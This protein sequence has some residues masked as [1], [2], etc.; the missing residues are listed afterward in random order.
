M[1]DPPAP[2]MSTLLDRV[3]RALAPRYDVRRE[4][5][6]GGMGV[7][8]LALDPRLH[9]DVAIKVLQPELA[10]A[11]G[12]E[13][14]LAEARF[15]A[16]LRH[17]SI[18]PVHD[19]GE[20]EGLL[21][22][23][24][25]LVEGPTLAARLLE[26]PLGPAAVVRLAEDLLGAL[27]VA[28]RAG[29]IHRDLKP[30]N[31]FL[32]G[33]RAILGDFGI[34][35]SLA[36]SISPLSVPGLL[37]GTLDY[38]APEQLGGGPATVRTDLYAVGLVL[39]A[40]ATGRR[41]PGLQQPERADWSGMSARMAAALKRALAYAPEDR[42]PDAAS[43]ARAIR[44][45]A[46]HRAGRVAAALVT[47][48]AL[49]YALYRLIP[50]AT[51]APP[52]AG[53]SIESAT[54]S[55][56]PDAMG[57]SLIAA[58]AAELAGHPDLVVR[59]F[60]SGRG[61][62]GNYRVIPAVS[63]AGGGV[64]VRLRLIAAEGML[65][66]DTT[67]EADPSTWRTAVVGLTASLVSH[68][69]L[70]QAAM[71]PWLPRQALPTGG[72]RGIA[73]WLRAEN[74]YAEERWEEAFDGFTEAVRL[75]G[76]CALC[77]FRLVDVDRWLGRDADTALRAALR[78]EIGRFPAHYQ[79]LIRSWA[80]PYPERFD[81][82]ERLADANPG[83]FLA[84]FHLGDELFHRGPLYGRPRSDALA[85]FQRTVALR[86]E[87]TPAWEH[88]A[89]LSI[90]EGDSAGS[91]R[92]LRVLRRA[93]ATPGGISFALRRFLEL[94]ARWRFGDPAA[95]ALTDQVLADSGLVRH[96]ITAAGGRFMLTA[97][98]P[99]G[100]V[101]LGRRLAAWEDR[102]EAHRSGLLAMLHGF[103]VLGRLDSVLAVGERLRSSDRDP[104]TGL[105][106]AELAAALVLFDPDSVWDADLSVTGPL[107]RLAAPGAA[108]PALRQRAAWMLSLLARR[109]GSEEEAVRWDRVVRQ[110]HGSSRLP[111]L[112]DAWAAAER[113]EV[114]RVAVLTHASL[115]APGAKWDDPFEDA[116]ARLARS[117]AYEQTEEHAQAV[118]E[119]RWH[120]HLHVFNYLQG[121]P[122]PGE[123]AWALGS[124]ARW[125]RYG[126]LERAGQS[127]AEMC[128]VLGAIARHWVH[129]GPRER[130]R[131]TLA[132]ERMARSGCAESPR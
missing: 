125:R 17:P 123:V 100:A 90:A 16:R 36:Q 95:A 64:R 48:A 86:P 57:D 49:A 80:V 56:L 119:L 22:Y 82:L 122:Q 127:G 98:A 27:A 9:R 66:V 128:A 29:V 5:A 124:V 77:R 10:T 92:A 62:P 6:R 75:D 65:M 110:V 23:V 71:D 34:A 53:V 73:A 1:P 115:L 118:D 31:V 7:V 15:L 78:A 108:D 24:M 105:Y 76:T 117:R 104:A 21:Y 42:W 111:A 4:L 85:P 101:A 116:V 132:R 18:I 129:G 41:W 58:L 35:R 113:G 38:M 12:A 68:V 102:P 97:E 106:A 131:A 74:L 37:V 25:D 72:P 14:F 88:L 130:A 40:A 43:F 112:L 51:P 99:Q 45:P 84:T 39:Y 52:Q 28:H 67:A 61:G 121:D 50:P 69:W 114:A 83:F 91:N 93:V 87:F 3:R 46:G 126:L 81:S 32:E 96:P 13:R 107:E 120:E 20:A 89:W 54:V 60:R 59:R 26:G 79:S 2:L 55:G 109:E 8:F 70:G 19:A 63:R 103:A 94:A 44:A 33:E 11:I 30:G 47:T